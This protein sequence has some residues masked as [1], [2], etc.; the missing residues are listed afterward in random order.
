MVLNGMGAKLLSR[1]WQGSKSSRPWGRSY[2]DYGGTFELGPGA[3]WCRVAAVTAS[4]AGANS[5]FIATT[6]RKQE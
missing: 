3:P 2:M 5:S 1:L 4:P 6:A